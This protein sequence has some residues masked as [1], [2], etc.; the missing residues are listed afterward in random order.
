MTTRELHWIVSGRDIT[1]RISEAKDHGAFHIADRAIPF[2][3]LDR[4]AHRITLEISG[5]RHVF[6][7]HRDRNQYSVWH[8]GRTYQLARAAKAGLSDTSA[9]AASGEINALMPGKI[10]RVDVSV[11]DTVAEKQTV[12]IMESMKMETTLHAPKTG[13]VSEVRCQP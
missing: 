5:T 4:T 2:R 13:R 7:I 8:N 9:P 6:Y 3:I 12:A 11:G 1:T 10:L